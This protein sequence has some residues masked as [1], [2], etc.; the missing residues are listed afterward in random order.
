MRGAWPRVSPPP[1]LKFLELLLQVP[2][3]DLQAGP[4]RRQRVQTAA[5]VG[6]LLVV[7][8]PHGGRLPRR[9]LL[10]L[11][12]LQQHDGLV[13]LQVLDPLDVV[14][15]AVVQVPQ[16]LLLLHAG[17]AAG[18]AGAAAAAAAAAG[19]GRGGG[20][21]HGGA[22]GGGSRC[23]RASG[24]EPRAAGFTPLSLCGFTLTADAA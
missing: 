14:G 13:A 10:L 19:G 17:R 6:Q 23:G 18:A 2:V 1:A 4:L 7:Q 24:G 12:Q 22:A 9:G 15:Q 3:L 16:L 5:D 8:A 11:P 21:G 20:G